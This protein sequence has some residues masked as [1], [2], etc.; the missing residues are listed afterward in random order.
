MGT[1]GDVKQNKEESSKDHPHFVAWPPMAP[2]AG[3][4]GM[5]LL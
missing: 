2:S 4:N 3:T 1:K 5:I